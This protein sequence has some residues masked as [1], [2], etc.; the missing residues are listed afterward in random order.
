[1]AEEL[2]TL[3]WDGQVHRL[4]ARLEELSTEAGKPRESDPATDPRVV[5]ARTAGYFQKHRDQVDYPT[6]R[7]KG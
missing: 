7:A 1:M 6:Y 3:L 4:L 2:V 5:L